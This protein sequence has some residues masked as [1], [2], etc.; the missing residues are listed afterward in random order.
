M[1]D[2]GEAWVS[3]LSTVPTVELHGKAVSEVSTS[4]VS[5]ACP[6]LGPWPA[7]HLQRLVPGHTI[8]FPFKACHLDEPISEVS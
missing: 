2:M 4:L 1:S 6:S 7:T 3:C 5:A 8:V